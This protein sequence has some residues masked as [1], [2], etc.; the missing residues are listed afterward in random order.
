MI[1]QICKSCTKEFEIEGDDLAFYEQM[2]VGTP[3]FCPGCRLK[4]RLLWR[5]EKSL[6]HRECDLCKKKIIS[7][8]STDKPYV[9]YCRECFHSDEWDP[10]SFGIDID[11]SRPFLEQF[12]ELQLKVPRI[13]SFV[14]Q[15][16]SSEYVNGAAYNKNCYMIFRSDS[17]EDLMFSYSTSNSRSS[18]D[19]LNCSECDMCYDSIGCS[20]CYQVLFSEDC[21]TSQNLILCKNCINCQDCVGCV[22]LH[23]VRYAIFNVMYTKEEYLEKI[24]ELGLESR[25]NL[26]ELRGK[27]KDFQIRFPVKYLHGLNNINVTG[28]YVSNSKNARVAFD[29]AELEDS[30]FINHGDHAKSS[31]DS[32]VLVDKSERS[33]NVVSGIAL[34]NVLSGNC[35]WHGYDISYSDTCENSHNLFGC[36][37][38]KKK[39][40][41]ILNKQYTKEEYEE[42]VPKIIDNM[43]NIHLNDDKVSYVY[44]DPLP[45]SFSPFSYNET[46]AHEY[47]P[48]TK[49]RVESMGLKWKET[50]DK[51]YET[52]VE[53]GSTP[54]EIKSVEDSI[55]K[56]IIACAHK[57][58][59]THQCTNAFKIT[60]DELNLY[61]RLNIPLPVLC[62]NCRNGERITKRNPCKLWLRSCMCTIENHHSHPG[63]QCQEE[64]ETSYSPERKEI[65][66]CE[67]CYQ[68]E[69]L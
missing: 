14:F 59:C 56:E 22:N 21:S 46:V 2:K 15:N 41:C 9:V 64:F 44:G 69:V 50:E 7:I 57:N 68:Q 31:Y 5:N 13:S 39:E 45:G 27:L 3:S 16:T 65:V 34:N 66:Y 67:Q 48:S 36:V 35:I 37:G 29:S 10:L 47:F 38:L 63:S 51:K 62:F 4:Q 26:N 32:Y 23:N 54:D 24:K 40:Y 1:K 11:F 55:T 8:Y 12:H 52:T 53:G 58:S 42:L 18:S 60:A 19:L 6:Y 20:K 43:K 17:N 25:T 61:R 28:D 49:L 33:Y 30:K